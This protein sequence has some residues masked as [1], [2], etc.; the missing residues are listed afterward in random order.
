MIKVRG[1]ISDMA[2][3]IVDDIPKI[4]NLAKLF[5][6]ELARKGNALYN[7]MPDI[8]SGLSDPEVGVEEEKFRE[9]IKYIIS[10]IEK[11]KHLEALVEKLCLRFRVTKTERQWRDLSFCLSI[12]SYSEKAIKKLIENFECFSDK[13]HED[14]VHEA[15]NTI[16]TQAKKGGLVKNDT[17]LAVEELNEKIEAARAKGVEDDT[18]N[19]RAQ[20]AANKKKE[21]RKTPAVARS[22]GSVVVQQQQRRRGK[23]KPAGI[24][25]SSSEEESDESQDDDDNDDQ[26]NAQEVEKENN[27]EKLNKRQASKSPP[28][29][30]KPPTCRQRRKDGINKTDQ[31]GFAVP[32]TPAAAAAVSAK[33]KSS[34]TTLSTSS[35]RPK[36]T[37]TR[38]GRR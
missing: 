13:L 12:F 31:E 32:K 8:I 36:R 26:E 34:S 23:G 16:M 4:S 3:C 11:D 27:Q 18:A 30:N 1:Q 9:I 15:F 38:S 21:M 19:K 25:E 22:R 37:M 33:A 35:S 2:L 20:N 17:K 29:D 10:L 24:D 6:T 14:S 7:V 5:F 28:T